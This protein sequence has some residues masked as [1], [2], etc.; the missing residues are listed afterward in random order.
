MITHKAI[1][2]AAIA[3]SLCLASPSQAAT[4]N[5]GGLI[6]PTGTTSAADPDLAGS[7]VQD[8]L[9]QFGAIVPSGLFYYALGNVQDR[10]VRSA[11]TG[12]LVFNQLTEP[13]T[14]LTDP[15]RVDGTIDGFDRTMNRQ[16]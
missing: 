2:P 3:L 10:V 6:F 15:S 13:L 9:E 12:D 7:I 8:D 11:T 4:L 14:G 16:F 1:F 5:P